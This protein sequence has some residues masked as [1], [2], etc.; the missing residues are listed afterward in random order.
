[1]KLDLRNPPA[2]VI[3]ERG[4]HWDSSLRSRMTAMGAAAK[5]LGG[6]HNEVLLDLMTG[7]E[8]SFRCEN[9]YT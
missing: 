3:L 9:G 2:A 4:T 8:Y 5:N 1:M 6:G 7:T